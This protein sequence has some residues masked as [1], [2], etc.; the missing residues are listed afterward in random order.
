V[1]GYRARKA[2]N[3]HCRFHSV[4]RIGGSDGGAATHLGF[5]K[6]RGLKFW[7]FSGTRMRVSYRVYEELLYPV[8]VIFF[9]ILLI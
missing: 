9:G 6:V 5:F 3:A 4:G 7:G 2:R 8:S 1:G